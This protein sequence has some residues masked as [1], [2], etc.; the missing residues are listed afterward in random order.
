MLRRQAHPSSQPD[1]TVNESTAVGQWCEMR[2]TVPTAQGEGR[3][4]VRGTHGAAAVP[5]LSSPVLQQD[6]ESLRG[7]TPT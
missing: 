1:S 2:G 3:D 4:Q 5:T 7:T 6:V